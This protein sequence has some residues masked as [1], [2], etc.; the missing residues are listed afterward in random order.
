MKKA[1]RR[2]DFRK[3]YPYAVVK[4]ETVREEAK[5]LT[6]RVLQNGIKSHYEDFVRYRQE[7]NRNNAK[8]QSLGVSKTVIENIGQIT[9]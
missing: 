6:K 7:D 8:N 4:R 2:F 9:L 3:E 1:E 5:E